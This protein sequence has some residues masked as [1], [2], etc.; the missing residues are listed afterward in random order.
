MNEDARAL[1][2]AIRNNDAA[3]AYALVGS[4]SISCETIM[5]VIG[6]A[7]MWHHQWICELFR[8]RVVTLKTRMW[9]IIFYLFET[10]K[11][12]SRNDLITAYYTNEDSM[13]QQSI[14]FRA[15]P[16]LF[17]VAYATYREGALMKLERIQRLV[18][19]CGNY[20]LDEAV[21]VGLTMI[22]STDGYEV[23]SRSFESLA[24][25]MI[26]T[27]GRAGLSKIKALF[28]TRDPYFTYRLMISPE[29]RTTVDNEWEVCLYPEDFERHVRRVHSL[30]YDLLPF[31]CDLLDIILYFAFEC[32]CTQPAHDLICNALRVERQIRGQ[33]IARA[34]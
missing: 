20:F 27:Q 24:Y 32:W 23:I 3:C 12:I 21:S 17:Y 5:T 2:D 33:Q 16:L 22:R 13:N 6:A 34:L 14:E 7:N 26:H 9:A 11:T 4:R 10:S 8:S 18:N 19:I 1:F 30:L 25:Y 29:L 31:S 28:V 15:L